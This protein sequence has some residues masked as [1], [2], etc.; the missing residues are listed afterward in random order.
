[1]R[2]PPAG[3]VLLSPEAD[4]SQLT[5]DD[6][7][8]EAPPLARRILL[9]F[10]APSRLFASLGSR[11]PWVDVLAISTAIAV[12]A[13]LALPPEFF[14]E[15]TVGAVDRR[16]RPV[17]ITSDPREIVRYGRY[18]G[19]MAAGASHP[20]IAFALAGVLTLLFTI[21]AGSRTPFIAHLSIASH[22]LLIPAAGTLLALIVQLLGG[23]TGFQATLD[24]FGA[25][26]LGNGVA[27]AMV[28]SL[29]L[30]TLWMLGVVAAGVAALDPRRSWAGATAVLVGLYLL[31]AGLV[32]W[33]TTR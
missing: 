3:A 32:A 30:F 13:V 16:G 26:R 14:V 8:A 19:M 22:A 29:N 4:E 2:L 23:G 33:A 31:L 21:I 17:E 9:V 12:V 1:M 18:L 28:G 7:T 25:G 5:A 11:P 15:Q 10:T 20:M 24:Q 6:S 27:A